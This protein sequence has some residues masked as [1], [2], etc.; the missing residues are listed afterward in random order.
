MRPERKKTRVHVE[1]RK[2]KDETKVQFSR[3]QKGYLS[4]VI[5][6][7]DNKTQKRDNTQD[8]WHGN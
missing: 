2:M 5:T 4:G 7:D 3:R 8:T 1:C 6:H